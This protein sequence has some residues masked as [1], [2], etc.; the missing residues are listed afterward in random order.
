MLAGIGYGTFLIF[1][2]I[3]Y[4]GVVY[5]YFCFPEFKGRSIESMD[6]LFQ[7][8]IFTMWKNAYPTESDKVRQDVQDLLAHKA[9]EEDV[10]QEKAPGRVGQHVE[11]SATVPNTVQ[12]TVEG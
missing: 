11:D 12:E 6:D 4:V 10:D 2:I 9:V 3:T 7:R 5:V 1:S 8:S